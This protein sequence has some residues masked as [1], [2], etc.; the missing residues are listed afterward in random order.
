MHPAGRAPEDHRHRSRPPGQRGQFYL[1]S[2]AA[3]AGWVGLLVTAINLLPIGQLDGGHILYGL[4]QSKQ[5]YLAMVAMVA[6]FALGFQSPTWWLFAG[7][8]LFFGIKHPPTLNDE[9]PLGKVALIMAIS[10]ILIMALSFTPVP[11]R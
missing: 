10:A 1:L 9:Q 8:G 4:F 7:F 11:F 6:L 2:E 3:F 5:K